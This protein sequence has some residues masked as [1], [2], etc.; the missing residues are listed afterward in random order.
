[1]LLW[2]ILTF[3]LQSGSLVGSHPGFEDEERVEH[4]F[5][6]QS[7]C[8]AFTPTVNNSIRALHTVTIHSQGELVFRGCLDEE[9][10]EEDEGQVPISSFGASP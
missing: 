3:P 5:P 4:V 6:P 7:F 2:N 10:E 8:V 9:I 1:M